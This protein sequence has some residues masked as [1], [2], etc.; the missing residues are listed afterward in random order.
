MDRGRGFAVQ[1]EKIRVRR[2]GREAAFH[3]GESETQER[4]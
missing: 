3:S 4:S 2:A 1:G